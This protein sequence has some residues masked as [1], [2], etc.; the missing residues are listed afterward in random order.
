MFYKFERLNYDPYLTI[1]DKSK[2]YRQIYNASLLY[3][4]IQHG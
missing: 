2:I 3:W 4:H 1:K